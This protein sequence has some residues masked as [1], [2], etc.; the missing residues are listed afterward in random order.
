MV[1]LKGHED[2]EC[3]TTGGIAS[4]PPP[5][6]RDI[7][8]PT[9]GYSRPG[10]V[11]PAARNTK[12]FGGP[13]WRGNN[14]SS[15]CCGAPGRRTNGRGRDN[16]EQEVRVRTNEWDRWDDLMQ[17]VVAEDAK[18]GPGRQRD[19][20]STQRAASPL[21]VAWARQ[22]LRFRARSRQEGEIIQVLPH[23]QCSN[24]NPVRVASIVVEAPKILTLSSEPDEIIIVPA[25]GTSETIVGPNLSCSSRAT[26]ERERLVD[27]LAE[28]GQ[29]ASWAGDYEGAVV[30][31]HR[32]LAA[33]PDD[34]VGRKEEILAAMAD[35][36][37]MGERMREYDLEEAV[38]QS[39][40][41]FKAEAER[42]AASQIPCFGHIPDDGGSCASRDSMEGWEWNSSSS[43]RSVDAISDEGPICL[44]AVRCMSSDGH[45]D[46]NIVVAMGQFD[47]VTS[48]ARAIEVP[49]SAPERSH[50]R[51][52]SAKYQQWGPQGAERPK[53]A[54]SF[55]TTQEVL[56]L[57]QMNDIRCAAEWQVSATA[58][59]WVHIARASDSECLNLPKVTVR[60]PEIL[61]SLCAKNAAAVHY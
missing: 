35:A 34:T 22:V 21:Q 6:I 17:V 11:K 56:A 4:T 28:L 59:S 60:L 43:L 3:Y 49:H 29:T 61:I 24:Q 7:R 1:N 32:A 37:R 15:S 39:I 9:H 2:L 38:A 53:L 58:A 51:A 54:F 42:I 5:S 55:L 46:G 19:E 57:N 50:S 45:S 33:D 23:A 36:E 13:K 26:L 25:G 14:F 30:T 52:S 48:A 41:S 47:A 27:R 18:T 44:D 31:F 20:N 12:T 8:Q 10:G 40:M 16:A